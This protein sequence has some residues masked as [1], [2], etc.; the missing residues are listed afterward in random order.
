[1]T[2]PRHRVSSASPIRRVEF[3]KDLVGDARLKPLR[4]H[5]VEEENDPGFA[6]QHAG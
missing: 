5:A 4:L 6:K 1:M 2:A 3:T